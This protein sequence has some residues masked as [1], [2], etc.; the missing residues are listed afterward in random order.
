[1]MLQKNGALKRTLLKKMIKKAIKSLVL[2]KIFCIFVLLIFSVG[3]SFWAYTAITLSV[4]QPYVKY[5]QSEI[6]RKVY[7]ANSCPYRHSVLE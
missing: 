3:I 1:M 7:C 2:S 6:V 4:T 5:R